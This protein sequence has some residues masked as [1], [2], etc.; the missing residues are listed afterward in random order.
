MGANCCCT[1]APPYAVDVPAQLREPGPGKPPEQLPTGLLPRF[2]T[3]VV[4]GSE[5]SLISV[6]STR[7]LLLLY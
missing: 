7:T 1:R 6:M 3:E 5:G 2:S 4:D